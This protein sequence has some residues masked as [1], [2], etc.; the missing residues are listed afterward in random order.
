VEMY[1]QKK[2]KKGKK[3]EKREK[4]EVGKEPVSVRTDTQEREGERNRERNRERETE[5]EKQRERTRNK[6]CEG[7]FGVDATAGAKVGELKSL[8]ADKNVFRLNVP[9]KDAV[10]STG[11]RENEREG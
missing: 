11:E 3:R 1:L 10:A 9:V 8:V 2:E 4:K 7:R 6:L 5:R